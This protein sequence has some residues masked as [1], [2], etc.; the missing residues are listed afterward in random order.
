LFL[1]PQGQSI[2]ENEFEAVV[3]VFARYLAAA[4]PD[5][6]THRLY[7]DHGDQTVDALYAPYQARVDKLVAR[8]G[9]VNG[10]NWLTLSF[11]GQNHSELSWSS[12]LETPLQ[13]LLFP[14]SAR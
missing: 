12:R 8:R 7:F 6:A 5:P 14:S 10:A 2:S 4:L 13:F 3:S 1:K 11:P 9:F